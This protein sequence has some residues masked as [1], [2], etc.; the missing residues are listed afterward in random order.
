MSACVKKLEKDSLIQKSTIDS[1][2]KEACDKEGDI[3]K[4]KSAIEELKTEMQEI[5]EQEMKMK[6]H[7]INRKKR[8]H[9]WVYNLRRQDADMENKDIRTNID[10][11]K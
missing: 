9:S 11:Y 1:R 7:G 6:K 8:G 4:L 10:T 2:N 5:K 3:T